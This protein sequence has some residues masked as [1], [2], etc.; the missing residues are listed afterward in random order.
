MRTTFLVGRRTPKCTEMVVMKGPRQ[1]SPI[2]GP[3]T[4]RALVR[5]TRSKAME[6]P[7]TYTVH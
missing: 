4:L 7:T 5:P 1:L 2:P 6:D 3:F